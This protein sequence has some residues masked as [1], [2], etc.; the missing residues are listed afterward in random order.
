MGFWDFLY[1]PSKL[2]S[3]E[4]QLKLQKDLTVQAEAQVALLN[5]VH[6]L[7][8]KQNRLLTGQYLKYKLLY[9]EAL[10]YDERTIHIADLSSLIPDSYRELTPWDAGLGEYSLE[11]ADRSYNAFSRSEWGQILSSVYM[12]VEES[13]TGWTEDIFDCDNYAEVYHA[14]ACLAFQRAGLERQGAVAIAWSRKHAYN[15]Y[16]TSSLETY[17]YEPQNGSQ[18]GLIYKS[19]D[20]SDIFATRKIWF[21]G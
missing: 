14:F 18:K 7:H 12:S 1:C 8:V 10:S 4:S 6:D 19:D 3:V 9:E 16:I 15:V 5:T 17:I 21:I 20:P 11:V 13:M 2:R